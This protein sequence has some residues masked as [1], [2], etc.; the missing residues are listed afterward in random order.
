L[1][2][3]KELRR[4]NGISQEKAARLLGISKNTWIRWEKG[5][6]RSKDDATKNEAVGMLVLLNK[7]ERPPLCYEMNSRA[8][9]NWDVFE[10]HVHTCKECQQLV[11]YLA[12]LIKK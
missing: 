10:R 11:K 5:Q 8:R 1:Q 12:A 6:F 3:L 4:K 7:M 9:W 2:D